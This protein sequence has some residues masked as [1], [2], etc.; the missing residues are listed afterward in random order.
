MRVGQT[1]QCGVQM[2]KHVITAYCTTATNNRKMY[3][4]MADR[5]C[6]PPCN[7]KTTFIGL[8]LC[9]NSMCK[10][11]AKAMFTKDHTWLM[12]H[13]MTYLNQSANDWSHQGV[14]TRAQLVQVSVSRCV[15]DASFVA[16]DKLSDEA[17]PGNCTRGLTRPGNRPKCRKSEI[18]DV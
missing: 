16:A 6:G 3:G 1:C 18:L 12:R 13:Y 17:S 10:R 15:T 4:Q 5:I 2:F 11:S 9:L 14:N 8:H 7:F